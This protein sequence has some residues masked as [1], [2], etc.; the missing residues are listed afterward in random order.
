LNPP[1]PTRGVYPYAPPQGEGRIQPR[2]ENSRK[3][4]KKKRTKGRKGK[5]KN[6]ILSLY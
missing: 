5:K 6:I 1:P 4:R 3:E 2:E